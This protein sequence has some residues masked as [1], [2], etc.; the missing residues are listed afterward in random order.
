VKGIAPIAAREISSLFVSPVAYVVLTLWSVLAGS[1]FL[2]SLLGFLVDEEQSRRLEALGHAA[3]LNLNDGLILPFL[4]SMWI[5][6][7]FLLPAVTMGLFASE[8]ANGTEELLLTSPVTGWDIVLGKFCAGA[9]FAVVMIVIVAF[10]PGILFVYGDPEVGK[11]A[12]GLLALFLVSLAYV[13]AGA[14]ASSLTRNQLIAFM[15]TLVI[16]IVLGMLFPFIVDAGIAGGHGARS[17][18]ADVIGW[19]STGRHAEHLLSGLVDTA[20]LAYFAAVV[21]GF[22]VLTKTAVESVRW[23]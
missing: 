10:F 6:M 4:G 5:V 18:L 20:D 17:D 3:S 11:T 2:S 8:K 14:F 19:A 1:F 12:A 16:L 15:L 22:L 23:R 9:A 21:A 13:A 7:L